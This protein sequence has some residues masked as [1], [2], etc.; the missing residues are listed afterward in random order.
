MQRPR[1]GIGE[2]HWAGLRPSSFAAMASRSRCS[3]IAA[4]NSAGPPALAI[5][6]VTLSLSP[7]I[8]LLHDGAHVCSNMFSKCR[9]HAVRPEEANESIEG[10][11]WKA[12][13]ADGWDLGIARR[14]DAVGRREHFYLSCLE[15]RTKRGQRCFGHLDPARRNVIGRILRVAIRDARH[16]KVI[17]LEEAGEQEID[18]AGC[19]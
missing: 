8:G 15:L 4:A 1:S 18:G 14:P 10:Q 3:C 5:W 12:R 13:L 16:L 2:D 11:L 9:R 7:K 17:F 6:P 19:A